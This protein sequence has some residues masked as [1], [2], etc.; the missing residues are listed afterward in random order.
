MNEYLFYSVEGETLAPEHD[1]E[2]DNCQ[3]L[4]IS[5]GINKDDALRNLL[6]ENLWIGQAGYNIA[7]IT[8]IQ[9]LSDSIK[10][11]IEELIEYLWSDELRRYEENYY[12]QNHIFRVL[13]RL[14]C[15]WNS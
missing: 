3:M 1:C 6:N 2:V 15:I 13:M 8:G 7:K 11:D 14:K 9:I 4:G 12:P 10:M 5:K